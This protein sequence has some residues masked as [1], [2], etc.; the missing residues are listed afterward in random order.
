[1]PES[2][3]Q[4]PGVLHPL[5]VVNLGQQHL[6]QVIGVMGGRPGTLHSVEHSNHGYTTLT[7]NERTVTLHDD[8]TVYI[9]TTEA[10]DGL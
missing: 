4:R 10:V 8:V 9:V 2:P 7:L 3:N 6:G 1:M 5:T